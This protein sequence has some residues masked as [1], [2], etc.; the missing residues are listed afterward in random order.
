MRGAHRIKRLGIAHGIVGSSR[1]LEQS[2]SVASLKLK[3]PLGHGWVKHLV[4]KGRVVGWP[5]CGATDVEVN[6]GTLAH[7]RRQK[8]VERRAGGQ[9]GLRA[10]LPAPD[11]GNADGTIQRAGGLDDVGENGRH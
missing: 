4:R 1:L 5:E 3:D 6:L 10:R 9:E 8:L 11:D 7:A 2:V